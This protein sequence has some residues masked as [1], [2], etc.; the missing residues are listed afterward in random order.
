MSNLTEK[1]TEYG[2]VNISSENE[3]TSIKVFG[4]VSSLKE[5]KGENSKF[6]LIEVEAIDASSEDKTIIKLLCFNENIYKHMVKDMIVEASCHISSYEKKLNNGKTL[7]TNNL[8]AHYI[9]YVSFP[10][11][12]EM[13]YEIA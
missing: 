2:T 9:T 8:I 10:S 6:M 1:T 7:R 3:K 4:K 13:K 11:A 5:F 12:E